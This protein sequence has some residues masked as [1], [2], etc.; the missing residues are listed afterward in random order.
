MLGAIGLAWLVIEAGLI[1]R[2]ARLTR[3]TRGLSKLGA[4][5]RRKR[6]WSA[7]TGRPARPRRARSAR[8]RRSTTCCAA[9]KEDAGRERIRA[10]QE[11]DMWHAV[12]HEIMSPLQA[13]WRCTATRPTPATATSAACSRRCACSTAAPARARLSSGSQLEGASLD[14]AAFLQQCRRKR[15]HRRPTLHRRRRSRCSCAPTSSARRRLRP[16]P[17]ERRTLPRAGTPITPDA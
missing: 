10:A 11:K 2:I 17:Q 14:I 7:T 6:I 16:H 13:C 4:G 9:C 1:R 15:R 5:R 8:Q 3:R 12:G